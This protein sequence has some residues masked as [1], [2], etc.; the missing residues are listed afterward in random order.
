MPAQASG[1]VQN[2]EGK[3]SQDIEAE[4][5]SVGGNNENSPLQE[6]REMTSADR[7]CGTDHTTPAV[8]DSSQ[9]RESDEEWYE[10]ERILSMKRKG[11][12]IWYKI[13]WKD[14][15]YPHSWIQ[16]QD[17]SEA[18]KDN[19]HVRR[20]LTGRLRKRSRLRS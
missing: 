19:Y 4:S 10:A 18:L 9:S 5:N 17:V 12:E 7:R 8:A 16:A 3:P 20:T 2:S 1:S 11:K 13:K 14:P 6:S 15:K